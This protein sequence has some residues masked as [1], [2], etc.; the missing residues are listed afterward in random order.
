[1]VEIGGR[2]QDDGVD[3]ARETHVLKLHGKLGRGVQLL[4]VLGWLGMAMPPWW[5]GM[6]LPCLRPTHVGAFPRQTM[7]H[8]MASSLQTS[9]HTCIG[10][11]IGRLGAIGGPGP[12]GMHSSSGAAIN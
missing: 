11:G 1:M 6:C 10:G 2:A 4:V 8:L 3:E 9:K 12:P 7:P 5:L